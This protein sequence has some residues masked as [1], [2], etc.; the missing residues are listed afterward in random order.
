[1]DH[2][3]R[4]Q[5][6]IIDEVH[7]CLHAESIPHWLD[8]GWALDFLLGRVTRP[9]S[10]VD[11]LIWK[12]D[13]ERVA[14]LLQARAYRPQTVRHPEEHIGF[15]K[16]EQYLSFTLNQLDANGRVV[17]AGR[18]T[19][20]PYPD[21]AFSGPDG[22][23]EDRHCPVL[24]AAGQL[25]VRENFHKHPAGAPRREVDEWAIKALRRLL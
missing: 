7:R 10:D 22:R 25:D 11:W 23:I 16:E 12:K 14:A 9:H 1:M 6:E 24:S 21:G 19:D 13:A 20:W 17:T 5:L 8:G 4:L 15:W 18:W 2:N 3:A